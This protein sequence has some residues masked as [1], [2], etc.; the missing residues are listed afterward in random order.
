MGFRVFLPSKPGALVPLLG[1]FILMTSGCIHWPDAPRMESVAEPPDDVTAI[2]H[3]AHP[4]ARIVGPVYRLA[5]DGAWGREL[6]TNELV[7]EDPRTGRHYRG[8]I[9]LDSRL[10]AHRVKYLERL[11]PNIQRRFF[12]ESVSMKPEARITGPIRVFDDSGK[13]Y[14]FELASGG[15]RYLGRIHHSAPGR[16][17]YLLH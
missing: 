4:G 13:V 7:F 8:S 14:E 17:V 6:V 12:E 2:V 3:E 11:P 9:G 10:T 16:S 5:R 15:R 1:A